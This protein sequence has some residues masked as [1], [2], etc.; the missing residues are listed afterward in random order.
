M[1][2]EAGWELLSDFCHRHKIK[3]S[4]AYYRLVSR[5]VEYK[6][7]EGSRRVI[8]RKGTDVKQFKDVRNRWES[9]HV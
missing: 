2:V 1:E 6:R 8:I 7:V 3:M 5:K 9:Y 4:K